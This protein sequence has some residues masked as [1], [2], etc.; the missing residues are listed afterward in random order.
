M[1]GLSGLTAAVVGSGVFG[2][3]TALQLAREGAVVTLYDPARLG[4]N[5]S[6]VAA[7]MLAPALESGLDAAAADHFPLL[8]RARDRWPDLLSSLGLAP[9]ALGREGALFVGEAAE[10][11]ALGA[12]LQVMGAQTQTP[13]RA[14]ALA[15]SPGLTLSDGEQALLA[16]Q[17]WRLSPAALL[18]ALRAAYGQA[19]GRLRTERIQAA[20]GRLLDAQGVPIA[21]DAVILASGIETSGLAAVAPELGLLRPVKGQILHFEGGPS[22]GPVIRTARG[23]L[24]PQPQGA[25]AGA[26][27]E[28]GRSDRTL[29]PGAL[30]MLR[31]EAARLF[32][33]LAAT[34]ARGMAG[35]RATT[36]DGLPLVG[37]SA[38]APE[39]LLCVGARRNG[40]LL[41]PLAAE[42]IVAT[43]AGTATGGGDAALLSPARFAAA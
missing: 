25:V 13:S 36:P 42:L 40:W 4:D 3:A 5:A 30:A 43:L 32:P 14:Q 34:P 26:T 8:L 39:V 17:D 2:L 6:G 22:T 1:S 16:P 37:R 38:G 21:A 24:A 28:P 7:G 18:P 31:A 33:D 27:M 20:G 10:V 9:D 29:D 19:G 11:A 12:R 23:Y 41:A 35:V 15:L